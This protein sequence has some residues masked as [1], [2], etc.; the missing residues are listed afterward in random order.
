M[1]SNKNSSQPCAWKLVQGH[2]LAKRLLDIHAWSLQKNK[3]WTQILGFCW[4][5]G[6][7]ST[8]SSLATRRG[9][10]RH[11]FLLW[12]L[13]RFRIGKNWKTSDENVEDWASAQVYVSSIDEIIG[14]RFYQVPQNVAVSK[15]AKLL[16]TARPYLDWYPRKSVRKRVKRWKRWSWWKRSWWVG[17]QRLDEDFSWSNS[18]RRIQSAADLIAR[19]LQGSPNLH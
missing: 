9:L 16:G 19:L 6:P 8:K 2:A 18:P 3:N 1:G 12:S 14:P 10:E 4:K 13:A 5:L 15:Q 11:K 7:Q 17:E